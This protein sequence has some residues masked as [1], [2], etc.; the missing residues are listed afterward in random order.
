MS[1]TAL[2]HCIAKIELDNFAFLP[3][4]VAASYCSKNPQNYRVTSAE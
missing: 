4:Q 2:N 3:F 1:S